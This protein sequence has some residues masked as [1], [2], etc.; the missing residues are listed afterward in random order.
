MILHVWTSLGEATDRAIAAKDGEDEHAADEARA[1]AERNGKAVCCFGAPG[2]GKTTATFRM[3]KHAIDKGGRILLALPTA[4]LAA[5]MREKWGEYIEIN[6]CAAAFGY[7]EHLAA[8]AMPS[9]GIYT[10]VLVDEISQLEGWQC[11]HILKLWRMAEHIPALA[12]V[13]DKGQMAGFGEVR[14]WHTTM[15]KAS[16]WT[17]T[18]K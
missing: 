8:G 18:L 12:L 11:D 1:D 17:R 6:T 5:R 3:I 10:L 4:Q 9:L 15:W 2:T 16:T 7:L 14:P 13:G